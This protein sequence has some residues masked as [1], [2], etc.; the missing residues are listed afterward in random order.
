MLTFKNL[1]F[2]LATFIQTSSLWAAPVLL[3]ADLHI[4]AYNLI[5]RTL[6]APAEVPD[7]LHKNFGPHITQEQDPYLNKPVFLFHL[8]AGTDGNTC[9]RTDRQRIEIKI[10]G[11]SNRYLKGLE[12]DHVT[13]KWKFKLDQKYQSSPSFTHIHQLKAGDGAESGSPII[14][15]TPREGRGGDPDQLQIIHKGESENF[16]V[17]TQINLAPLLGAW[18]TAYEE[19]TYGTHGSYSITLKSGS[20]TLLNYNKTDL[21]VWRNGAAFVRPKWGLYRSLVSDTLRDEVVRFADFCLSNGQD[22]C[23]QAFE[24]QQP[25]PTPSPN[26]TTPSTGRYNGFDYGATAG[27]RRLNSR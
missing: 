26:P 2:S 10:F 17:L 8:H 13:Y 25:N 18:I 14:T 1:T 7:C 21:D 5:N 23:S 15:I 19:I 4:D 22:S 16:N 27:Q 6:E 24:G 12:G 11:S 20:K 9:E 3:S